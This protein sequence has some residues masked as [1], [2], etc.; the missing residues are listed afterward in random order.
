MAVNDPELSIGIVPVDAPLVT[1]GDINRGLWPVDFTP[2]SATLFSYAM[3]NYWHTNYRARQGGQLHFRYVLTSS[4]DF[5]PAG[6]T[7]LGVESRRALSVDRIS[8]QDKAGISSESLPAEGASFLQINNPDVLLTTWKLAE[9]GEGTILRLEE[10]AGKEQHAALHL[11]NA[12]VRSA[13]LCNAM[14]DDLTNLAV[15]DQ[16]IQITMKPHEVVTIRLVQ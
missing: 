15:K 14:E 10:I 2:K 7:R 9:N 3:N 1:F 13:R 4:H 5:N 6:L 11:S 12:T 8:N 16:S